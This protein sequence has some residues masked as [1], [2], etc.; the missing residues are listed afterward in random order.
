MSSIVVV[1]QLLL[2]CPVFSGRVQSL[3]SSPTSLF[4]LNRKIMIRKSVLLMHFLFL[5]WKSRGSLLDMALEGIIKHFFQLCVF[6]ILLIVFSDIAFRRLASHFSFFS[7]FLLPISS[8]KIITAYLSCESGEMIVKI[9]FSAP[10]R[11]VAYSD[12]DRS[13][14]CKFYG[15]GSKYFEMRLPLK[16]CGTKQ[17]SKGNWNETTLRR[18]LNLILSS[19]SKCTFLSSRNTNKSHYWW[20]WR[21]W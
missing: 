2:S 7:H 20:W 9:N 10:F 14:P 5:W 12:Y 4:Q 11:G 19:N 1:V 16:G 21:W 17:V 3:Q 15:D 8:W 18:K 13:S 6:S